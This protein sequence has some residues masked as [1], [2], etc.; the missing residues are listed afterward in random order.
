M[1]LITWL[2]EEARA[3]AAKSGI[4]PDTLVCGS[5][6]AATFMSNEAVVTE[7]QLPAFTQ[8]TA[9]TYE[10]AAVTFIGRYA[11]LKVYEYDGIYVTG[12]VSGADVVNDFI[13][14]DQAILASTTAAGSMT[15]L[16][17]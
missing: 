6:A 17:P 9:P 12:D 1:N 14:P 15:L 13:A 2:Q 5:K 16:N 8:D 3:L 4:R 10:D 11:G 7:R